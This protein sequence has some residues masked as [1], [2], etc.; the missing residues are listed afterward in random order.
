[1]DA[2]TTDWWGMQATK[3]LSVTRAEDMKRFPRPVSL[4]TIKTRHLASFDEDYTYN[5][6]VGSYFVVYRKDII[7]DKSFRNII[8]SIVKQKNKSLIIKKYEGG[9]T[10]HLLLCGYQF[11]TYIDELYPFHPIYTESI[12]ELIEKG[13]PFF[14]RFMLAENHYYVSDLGNWKQKIE[15]IIPDA[16]LTAIENNL[17]RVSNVEKLYNNFRVLRNAN[18]NPI[19]PRV[20]SDSEI[21]SLD[22]KTPKYDNWWA[23]PVCAYDHTFSGNERAVFE[24]IRYNKHIKKIILTRSKHID[25][26]GE[27]VEIVPLKS[28]DGQEFL[29][30]SKI[31]FIKHTV[32]ENVTYPLNAK[33]HHFIELWHGIPLKRIGYASL[34]HKPI[35]KSIAKKHQHLRAVISSSKVDTLAMASGFYP[36]SYHDVWLTG[37]PRNDFIIRDFD[38]LP[39]DLK[40]EELKLCKVLNG[41]KLILFCPTF[42]N[43]SNGT[44]YTFSE[45]EV[46]ELRNW[47]T[48][49]NAVLGIREH[50][51]DKFRIYSN[52]LTGEQFLDLSSRIYPNIEILFRVSSALITDYSSCFVDYILTGKHLVSFAYDLESYKNSERG[53][54]YD[55]E[56]CFPGDICNSFND[57]LASLKRA[58]DCNFRNTDPAY[59]W[60]KKLFFEFDDDKNSERVVNRAKE[61]IGY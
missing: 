57:V 13:F 32:E 15:R 34:D 28:K 11:H 22:E 4:E 3:G 30:K 19:Y 42:R 21:A 18:Y 31:V 39:D 54:F 8:N 16:N 40:S 33:H 25:L 20:Y 60:K 45:D 56:F 35:L 27:N 55:M 51:A 14:K 61:L 50:I 12:Y 26:D 23:F 49:N 38:A 17:Y 29:L 1:M 43:G 6:H 41:R 2:I 24:E 52:Q 9:F 5:F 59:N 47:L 10:R 48:A 7:N 44:G 37:L 36:L 53:L 46:A 58:A